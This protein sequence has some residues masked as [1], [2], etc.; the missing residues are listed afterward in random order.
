MPETAV[1]FETGD[2]V[3]QVMSFGSPTPVEVAVQGPNLDVNRAH[4]ER[5]RAELAK[6][7]WLRDLQY[8]Q[9]LDYPTLDVRVDRERAG[10][11]GLTMASVA[12]SLVAATSSSRFIEPNYWRDPASGNAFQV[13]VEIPQHKMA[14]LRDVWD[15]PLRSDGT[16]LGE[17]ATLKYGTA[18]GEIERYNM[19]RVVSLTANIH[20]RTLG[21]VD[22]EIRAALRRAGDPPPG[23]RVFVRGQIPPLQ[24]TLSGLRVGLLLSIAVIFLLLAANFQS[25]RLAVAVVSAVPAVLFGVTLM[26][27]VTG[28]TLNVQSFMGAIMAIGISVANAILLVTYAEM[29]RREGATVLNA[30]LEGGS[31]R[32]RAILM[33][34]TAMI[35][36]MVPIALGLGQSGEQT[37][38]LGKAVIGGLLVATFATLTVL[39]SVYAI[40]QKRAGQSSPSLDP[41]DPASQYYEP[42]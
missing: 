2:I 23:A 12:R 30:A 10:Q 14:S 39:P 28:S 24:E 25:L 42:V 27:L 8:A 41:N 32:L 22:S 9:P 1:S 29:S 26:L 21:Q 13:Q 31:G 16:V 15:V 40:L 17:V 33:T 19:Q 34:A 38:P 20:G 36:G 5:V 4:A 35:A 37:A 18:P 3:S 6:V 11:F 7:P